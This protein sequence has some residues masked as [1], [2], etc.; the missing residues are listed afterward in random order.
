MHKYSEH[1]PLGFGEVFKCLSVH[2]DPEPIDLGEP[3]QISYNNMTANSDNGYIATSSSNSIDNDGKQWWSEDDSSYTYTPSYAY[4][5]FM[6]IPEQRILD[7]YNCL[8]NLFSVNDFSPWICQQIPEAAVANQYSFYLPDRWSSYEFYVTEWFFEGSND[9]STW[10]ELHHATGMRWSYRQGKYESPVFVNDVAYDRYR[11]RIIVPQEQNYWFGVALFK[12]YH[13]EY[14]G[15]IEPHIK[16]VKY[17]KYTDKFSDLV[18]NKP[19]GKY[20]PIPYTCYDRDFRVPVDLAGRYP[21]LFLRMFYGNGHTTQ[22][23]GIMKDRCDVWTPSASW[24]H[25]NNGPFNN[26]STFQI[27]GSASWNLNDNA[28]MMEQYL[29]NDF[30]IEFWAYQTNTSRGVVIQFDQDTDCRLLIDNYDSRWVPWVSSNGSN[31]DILDGDYAYSANTAITDEAS[32]GYCQ[33]T[34]NTWQHVA[35]VHHGNYWYLFVDGVLSLIRQRSGTWYQNSD[36]IQLC[37]GHG[38]GYQWYGRLYDLRIWTTA[39]YTVP[40]GT[41]T[42]AQGTKFFTPETEPAI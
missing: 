30:T 20:T 29:S 36:G 11:L 32:R 14:N 33:I 8:G 23:T 34:L 26:T 38:T 4:G 6:D 22:I 1:A 16:C 18:L 19:F 13:V 17:N 27:T 41:T 40:A 12:F 5:A 15:I 37:R 21:D 3:V 39:K 42:A 28:N 7:G 24:S 25:N 35:F 10:T 2:P 9:G 31:W